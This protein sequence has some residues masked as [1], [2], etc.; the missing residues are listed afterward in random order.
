MFLSNHY[1]NCLG[2][3]QSIMFIDMGEKLFI[4]YLFLLSCK[5]MVMRH[6]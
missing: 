4:D 3:N 6:S 2:N 1:T 5:I